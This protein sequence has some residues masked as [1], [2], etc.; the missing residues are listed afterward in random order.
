MARKTL[1]PYLYL[2]PAL[3]LALLFVYYPFLR[4]FLSSFFTLS[5]K[6]EFLTFQ[7]FA[8]YQKLFT[9]EVFYESLGNTFLFIL[10]FV[11]INLL[12]ISLAVALTAKKRRG[13]ALPE[14]MFLLPMAMGMSSAALL[15]KT[16]FN[17]T[18][19][20]INRIFHTSIQWNNEALP[21]M[22]SVVFLGVFLDFGL[23]YILLLS[24][25]R[26]LDKG[27]VEAALVDGAGAVRVFFSIKLPLI[28]PT[29]SFIL[30]TSL[31]DA[32]LICAPIMVMTEGGPYRSTQTIVY[33]FYLEAFK[34]QNYAYSA[35]IST[36]VFIIAGLMILV[37]GQ[38]DKRRIHY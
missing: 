6:G 18:L 35:A 17:P 9:N 24:S 38:L 29:L 36:V 25:F 21:A 22:F 12:L 16:M 14:L 37:A 27:P 19:G 1:K 32:F 7:G 8:N 2:L 5:L 15:F 30:F 4:S 3:F 26:N 10:L 23:D 11:P 28:M 34:N 13:S 31:K 20:V 33:Y